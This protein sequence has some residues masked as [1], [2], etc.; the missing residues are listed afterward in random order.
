MPGGAECGASL[1]SEG[2]G[3]Q[4][5]LEKRSVAGRRLKE[6]A[7]LDVAARA[8]AQLDVLVGQAKAVDVSS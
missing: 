4:P 1:V 2:D 5:R 8:D 6:E 7:A 3:D